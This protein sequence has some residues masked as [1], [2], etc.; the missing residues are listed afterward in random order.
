MATVRRRDE[1]ER[2]TTL[3]WQANRI[4]VQ[5]MNKH[6][7]PALSSLL[8]KSD[9]EKRVNWRPSLAEQR[10]NLLEISRRYKIP[11]KEVTAA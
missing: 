3:A 9:G 2:D 7:L 5:T 6:R 4:Y 1:L 8:P 10:S 11:I